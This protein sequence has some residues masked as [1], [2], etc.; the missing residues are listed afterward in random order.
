MVRDGTARPRLALAAA[1]GDPRGPGGRVRAS[2]RRT[3]RRPR[4]ARPTQ[5]PWRTRWARRAAVARAP[6]EVVLGV[7]TVVALGGRLYGKPADA[8]QARETLRA[9]SGATPHGG[10]RPRADRARAVAAHGDLRHGGDLPRARRG[11]RSTGTWRAA[12][13]ASAPA[14]TRSR[15]RAA[16]SSPR[17]PATGP[18]WSACRSARC[19]SCTRT[20]LGAR[21][22]RFSA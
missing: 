22:N 18:T 12:S 13:G 9:L 1:P 19:S 11:R 15:A 21:N 8:A 7:D 20:L 4:A 6:D 10:Q 17:S 14:A 3:S 2:G 16:R 5:W